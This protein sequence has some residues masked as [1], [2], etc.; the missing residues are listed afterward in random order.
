M[1]KVKVFR[2][3]GI[4]CLLIFLAY[5]L[6]NSTNMINKSTD[7]FMVENGTLSYEE[8]A[9]GYIIRDEKLLKGYNYSIG[10]NHIVTYG[11]RVSKGE[12]VFRYYSNNEEEI[13]KQL[14]D[15]DKKIDEALQNSQKG[16]IPIDITN[17]ENEI[18][19]VLDNLYQANDTRVINE[20]KK[21]LNTYVVKK[22]EIAGEKSEAGSY[23]RTLIDQRK[24]LS[25]QLTDNSE[26]IVTQT[27]GI[28]SYRVDGLEEV[29]ILNNNDFSYLT[30][31]L[32]D[33]FRL[34]VGTSIPESKEAGK[35]VNNFEC[36]IACPIN[37][38]KSE[39][40]KVR[41]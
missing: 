40:V 23:I 32:L 12:D 6:M 20:Y 38:E 17:L 2:L 26:T 16:I 30:T 11:S 37:T 8:P 33:G 15:L 22:A 35:I 39:I 4:I 25:N 9:E 14:E 5:F 28:I 18:E 21:K 34:N 3:L 27:P 41:R 36:Y 29:L 7:T 19:N 10:L 31:E 24:A 1:S 13:N